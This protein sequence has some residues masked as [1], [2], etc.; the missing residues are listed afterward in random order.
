MKLSD[1]TLKAATSFTFL[2]GKGNDDFV[3]WE[4]LSDADY[5]TD[6]NFKPPDTANVI[7]PKFDF[8]TDDIA[9]NFFQYVFPSIVGHAKIIDKYLSNQHAPYFETV[10]NDKIVF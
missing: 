8:T 10:Q 2:G 6:D 4:I 1:D 7:D 9:Q 3:L 5:I